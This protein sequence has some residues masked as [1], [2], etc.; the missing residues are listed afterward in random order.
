MT[1]EATGNRRRCPKNFILT[2]NLFLRHAVKKCNTATHE[3]EG[4]RYPWSP[5]R[6]LPRLEP[7]EQNPGGESR[8]S[9]A[10]FFNMT[11]R[12]LFSSSKALL[13]YFAE[14]NATR[15]DK[16]EEVAAAAKTPPLPPALWGNRKKDN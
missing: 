13:C 9:P 15:S 6:I 11:L 7:E 8:F 3:T 16:E 2:G 5:R 12:E 14:K 1:A 4:R 10:I